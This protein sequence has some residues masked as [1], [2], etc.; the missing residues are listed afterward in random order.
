M[1]DSDAVG[2]ASL[3]EKGKQALAS[4]EIGIYR[5][6]RFELLSQIHRD[7]DALRSFAERLKKRTGFKESVARFELDPAS[8]KILLSLYDAQTG[9]IH[10][11]L[12]AEEVEEG[13]KQLEETEDNDSPL[14]TFFPPSPSMD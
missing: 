14:S 10:L 8:G 13:L 6:G 1:F 11:K 2:V 7:S 12:S 3:N 5:E 4:I 9:E